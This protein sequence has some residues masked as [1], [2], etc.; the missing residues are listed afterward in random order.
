MPRTKKAN[1]I[2]K[3]SSTKKRSIKKNN[4]KDLLKK[5]EVK[6]KVVKNMVE[7][8]NNNDTFNIKNLLVNEVPAKYYKDLIQ[9]RK[10]EVYK[11]IEEYLETDT[12]KLLDTYNPDTI[13]GVISLARLLEM[14]ALFKKT[15]LFFVKRFDKTK[16]R[17]KDQ[18][19]IFK[20]IDLVHP[21][22]LIVKET[23]KKRGYYDDTIFDLFN[24]FIKYSIDNDV[25]HSVLKELFNMGFNVKR[26]YSQKNDTKINRPEQLKNVIQNGSLKLFKILVENGKRNTDVDFDQCHM[27]NWAVFYDK[28]DIVKYLIE[29]EK[30]NVN[31][32]CNNSYS[33]PPKP[34]SAT[35]LYN[36]VLK[37]N[38]RMVRYLISK[39]A[40]VNLDSN[41]LDEETAA[42]LAVKL[43]NLPILKI[44]VKAGADLDTQTPDGTL[45][46]DIAVSSGNQEM[47]EYLMKN[48]A[49]TE[50]NESEV[51]PDYDP[52]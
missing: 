1:N 33:S 49:R 45:A 23:F 14:N 52:Y 13:I 20:L 4:T 15:A 18:D 46:Y 44:L 36:A 10:N 35:P 22:D 51:R 27:L 40:D 8:L 41:G 25:N 34:E 17:K 19:Q 29:K 5:L 37:Q 32:Y 11:I 12:V 26:D 50:V 7:D 30:H 9:K 47:V 42:F 38:P 39:N 48:G 21:D 43:N 3:S 28:L 2:T 16:L 24:N 31:K 6:S